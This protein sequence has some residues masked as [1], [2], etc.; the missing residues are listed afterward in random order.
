M[1]SGR[2]RAPS[3]QPGRALALLMGVLLLAGLAHGASAQAP[4]PARL[5]VTS[6]LDPP[7][8]S[9]GTEALLSLILVNVG[10]QAAGGI[11]ITASE[12]PEGLTFTG[13]SASII[14]SLGAGETGNR[15]LQVAADAD[16]PTGRYLVQLL[17]Q[18][19]SVSGATCTYSTFAH[20]VSIHVVDTAELQIASVQPPQLSRSSTAELAIHVHNPSASRFEDIVL[21]WSAPGDALLPLGQDSTLRLARLAAN[22]HHNFTVPVVVDGDAPGGLLPITLSI[23]YRDVTGQARSLESRVG[24]EIGGIAAF[25]VGSATL[26]NQ[27]L[28]VTLGNVGQNGASSVV[29][30]ALDAA[31]RALGTTFLGTM[32]PGDFATLT[33][34]VDEG[35]Q[36]ADIA[37]LYIAYTDDLGQRHE[38][39]RSLQAT[40]PPPPADEGPSTTLIAVL[41]VVGLLILIGVVVT[42]RRRRQ[43]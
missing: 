42:I 23:T 17:I 16:L 40:E 39:T 3:R 24:I 11:S 15:A 20:T 1:S 14:G 33:I 9:P 8:L 29:V 21:T 31:Q 35:V 38:E 25:D 36:A 4:S 2:R 18:Y 37:S 34:T 13:A 19:C 6:A 12:A 7:T 30:R 32:D 28:T 5:Q 26:E 10:G 22:A 41:A 27:A 43:E